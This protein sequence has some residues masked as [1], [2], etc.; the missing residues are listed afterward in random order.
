MNQLIEN[1]PELVA[2]DET[3]T[4]VEGAVYDEMTR[5]GVAQMRSV[6]EDDDRVCERCQAN[7]DEGPINIGDS[8][9]TGDSVP[10]FHNRC[11]CNIVPA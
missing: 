8:F 4:A 5:L 6:S 10:P 1:M 11:R 7:A 3:T 2:G 9:A